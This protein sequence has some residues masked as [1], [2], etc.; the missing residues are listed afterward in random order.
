MA[1]KVPNLVHKG[2]CYYFRLRVPKPLFG[3]FDKTEISEALGHLSQPQAAIKA[4]EL[5]ADLAPV[6]RTP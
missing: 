1:K 5:S 4:R 6:Y 3:A 2:H